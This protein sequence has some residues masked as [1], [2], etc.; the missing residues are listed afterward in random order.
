MSARRSLSSQELTRALNTVA[1][2]LEQ[3]K[4]HRGEKRL[5]SVSKNFDDLP[6]DAIPVLINPVALQQEIESTQGGQISRILSF[7]RNTLILIP[8]IVTWLS[9]VVSPN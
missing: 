1:D 4:A 3:Q 2:R 9:L 7:I 5:R 6:S 8:L